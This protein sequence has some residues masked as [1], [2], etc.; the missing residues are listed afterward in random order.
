MKAK[1]S[2]KTATTAIVAVV[3]SRGVCLLP[4][5]ISN[6]RFRPLTDAYDDHFEREDSFPLE[7]EVTAACRSPRGAAA[8]ARQWAA[9]NGRPV[10]AT[11]AQKAKVAWHRA[12]VDGAEDIV[13]MPLS[14]TAAKK[15]PKYLG[16]LKR[17]RIE[18]AAVR[19]NQRIDNAPWYVMA[20][21]IMVGDRV[22][23][24]ELAKAL[25]TAKASTK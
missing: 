12:T 15:L 21:K 6:G 1:Q 16:S 23:K 9:P 19:R 18:T 24:T 11:L 13:A 4:A 3:G 17:G 14:W 22:S 25:A 5:R 8:A 10:V 2:K 20:R 7:E